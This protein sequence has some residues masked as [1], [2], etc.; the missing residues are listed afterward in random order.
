M[1]G[2]TI[3]RH[4]G[5]P[6]IDPVSGVG[7]PV[8]TRRVRRY[9][10]L[11]LVNPVVYNDHLVLGVSLIRVVIL[12]AIQ[13]IDLLLQAW[14]LF[15]LLQQVLAKL[16]LAYLAADQIEDRPRVRAGNSPHRVRRHRI[17][18]PDVAGTVHQARPEEERRTSGQALQLVVALRVGQI[19]KLCCSLQV[20]GWAVPDFR[21]LCVLSAS[22]ETP[23]Q[24]DGEKLAGGI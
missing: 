6:D 18:W 21:A 12:E 2:Q 9:S 16:A 15:D 8:C 23:L 20:I 4:H 3:G 19:G 7:W 24:A 17:P 11:G 14:D 13:A 1:L 22:R 10:L 5:L